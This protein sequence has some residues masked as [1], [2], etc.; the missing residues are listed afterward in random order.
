MWYRVL[1]KIG[2]HRHLGGTCCLC[3]EGFYTLKKET[4]GSSESLIPIFLGDSNVHI[5]RREK[6]RPHTEGWGQECTY[7]RKRDN[8]HLFNSPYISITPYLLYSQVWDFRMCFLLS[9]VQV[10]VNSL[11]EPSV[12]NIRG[13]S[14]SRPTLQHPGDG[15]ISSFYK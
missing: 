11:T 12:A 2:K 9:R 6:C 4:S 10:E 7:G 3:A 14:H 5:H 1:W 15:V 13:D 8:I